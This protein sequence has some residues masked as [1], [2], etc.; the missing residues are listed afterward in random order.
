MNDCHWAFDAQEEVTHCGAGV[1]WFTYL[2]NLAHTR[3][4]DAQQQQREHSGDAPE[5]VPA[6]PA[7]SQTDGSDGPSVAST[8]QPEPSPGAAGLTSSSSDLPDWVLE[9]QRFPTVEQWFHHQIRSYF[10]GALKVGL[11]G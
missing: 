10:H 6:P 1:R 9:A 7:S 4:G 5:Q 8:P 3:K 11:D 2:Y